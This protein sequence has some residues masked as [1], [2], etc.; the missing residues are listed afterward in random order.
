[1]RLRVAPLPASSGFAGDGSSSCPESRI[2]QHIWRISSGLPH[3]FAP[4]VVPVDESLGCPGFCIFRPCRRWSFR[5]PRFSHPSAHPAPKLASFPAALLLRLRLPIHSA[6]CLAS[7]IF[8]L[9]RRRIPE[10]PRVS[11]P[12]APLVLM[13]W[14][15]PPHCSS[16]DASQCVCEF[17]RSSHLPALP[18][19]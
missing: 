17:P 18:R 3:S 5:L 15:A 13:P 16:S 7:C 8:R 9:C 11:R 4:P 2:L 6:S 14:V 19:V 1:M 10:L 12:S